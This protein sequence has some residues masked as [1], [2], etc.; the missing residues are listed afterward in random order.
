[1]K[2]LAIHVLFIML[3]LS[4]VYS[5]PEQALKFRP[6]MFDYEPLGQPVHTDK[7]QNHC[8]MPDQIE[9]IESSIEIA[10]SGGNHN[11]DMVRLIIYIVF[12][13]KLYIYQ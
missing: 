1:M 9:G 5:L 13:I 8:C 10:A 7:V 4:L 11:I 3:G 12:L 6:S 2:F